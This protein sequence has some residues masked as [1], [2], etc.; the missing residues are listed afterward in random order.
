[1][2]RFDKYMVRVRE[3]L[4]Y[5]ATPEYLQENI[6]Y[7]YTNEEVDA[8]LNYFKAAMIDGLSPYIALLFFWDYKEG[9]SLGF[10]DNVKYKASKQQEL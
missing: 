7:D 8:N 9:H 6:T 5:N 3:Q 2:K 4:T 10:L 1:M